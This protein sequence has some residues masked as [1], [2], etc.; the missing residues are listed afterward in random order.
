MNK[1]AITFICLVLSSQLL[2]QKFK[3]VYPTLVSA[4]DDEALSIL[5][6]YMIDDL[7]HPNSNFRLALIYERR[8][9]ASDP[10]TQ[11]ER[12]LA[13]ANEAK[14]RFTKSSAVINEKEVSKNTGYYADFATGFDGKGRP[15]VDFN[16]INQKIRSGYDSAKL[17]SD[18]MPKIYAYFT[19]SV[20]YH[21]KAIK[22]YNEINGDFA[23]R[24]K[25]LL[26]YNDNLKAKLEALKVNYDSSIVNL[27][28]Y[29]TASKAFDSK[30]FNQSYTIKG[31][32]TY[33]LQG[34]LTSPNF[35]VKN[36]EIWDYK[37]WA[38]NAINEVSRDISS[39]RNDLNKAEL[40]L[41]ASL[42]AMSPLT[43]NT[44]LTPYKVDN[45]LIFNLIKYDNK[46]L[47]VALLRYKQFK[48]SLIDQLSIVNDRDTTGAKDI[49]LIQLGELIYKSKDA[50][51]LLQIAERRIELENISKYESYFATHYNGEAGL[52]QYMAAEKKSAAEALD[53]GVSQMFLNLEGSEVK[54]GPEFLTYRGIKIPTIAKYVN[55]DSMNTELHTTHIKTSTDGSRYLVGLNKSSRKPN[56]INV[57]VAKTDERAK[58]IWY[59]EFSFTEDKIDP[60]IN[61]VGDVAITPEGCAVLVRSKNAT[62]LINRLFYINENGE[63]IFNKEI[64]KSLYPRKM[65]Y[66]EST[67]AFILA[68][69]GAAYKQNHSKKE[70]LELMS[71]N[72]LGDVL[73]SN[74]FEYAGNIVDLFNVDKGFM[75]LGNY[76]EIK[77]A[78]GKVF[79]T[80]VNTGQTNAFATRFTTTGKLLSLKVMVSTS[81]YHIDKVVK[82]NDKIINLLGKKSSIDEDGERLH[83]IVNSNPEVLHFEL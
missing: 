7:D 52:K 76:S 64:T 21:D 43:H 50:D 56:H 61:E 13:N 30:Q 27:D 40:G 11:Y 35:L 24:D 73:W 65:Q 23:S 46:S 29:L 70:E 10:I 74:S 6:S 26:M 66:V 57:F 45:K 48:Q 77:G 34:L 18:K 5:K 38:D 80:K 55:P 8:Y 79:R 58:V 22:L 44:N 75:V 9:K 60:I 17:F 28:K 49:Y 33:R 59:K 69:K 51:S 31:I 53:K 2:A 4:S 47:P 63:E 82:I 20:N 19:N 25:L 16:T 3:D 37:T 12:T 32:E 14:L 1:L 83:I 72:I 36:I 42:K 54:A 39:L 41:N 71:I 67:N 15:I 62:G 68:H 78:D 81:N